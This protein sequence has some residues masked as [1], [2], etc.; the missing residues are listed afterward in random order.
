MRILGISNMRIPLT[1][2]LV[3]HVTTA[4]SLETSAFPYPKSTFPAGDLGPL[5]VVS[6]QNVTERADIVTLQTLAG[7]LARTS[8]S[9]YVVSSDPSVSGSENADSTIFWLKEMQRQHP[10][11][12]ISFRHLRGDLIGLLQRFR[13][14]ITGY[15]RFDPTTN[16]TNAAINYCAGAQGNVIAAKDGDALNEM[17]IPM[18]ADVSDL[19]PYDVFLKFKANMSNRMAAFQ[20]DDG[21]KAQC[22]SAYAVFGRFPVV[23]HPTGGSIAFDDV[24]SNFREDALNAA[25]GWTSSDEHEYTA[26]ITEAGGMVHA[27][28]FLFNVEVL[29]NLPD[30]PNVDVSDDPIE[31][32][33]DD[34]EDVHTV[35]F[36][37][38]DGDNLQ[39]LA[40]GWISPSFYGSPLRG[41][42]PLGWS[43]SPAAAVLMPTALRYVRESMT[44][45]DSLSSGPS[46]A[47]YVYPQLFG[48][49]QQ[50]ALFADAT[51]TM[52][53]MSNMTVANVIGVVPSVESVDDLARQDNIEGLIYFTFGKASEGYSGLHGNFDY[54]HETPVVG[55]RLNMW[56]EAESGDKV[57]VDGLVHELSQLPK[58]RSDA[59]AYS[60]VVVHMGSHNYS[61]VVRATEALHE[62]GGFDVVLPETLLKRIAKNA[63][64]TCPMPFGEWSNVVGDLPKCS[65]ARNG[66]CMFS[67]SSVRRHVLPVSCDLKVC[68]NLT[69]S[70][71]SY[72]FVCPDGEKCP[73][74]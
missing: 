14:N 6:T 61:D 31:D 59:R 62:R 73:G 15:V 23:E 35:A 66:D 71:G 32:A 60:I 25:M 42:A 54:V 58:D 12:D 65:I 43:Y 72:R 5:F 7:V 9:I 40:N 64:P 70:D 30:L 74:V 45:N 16:S 27:S 38:S 11:L 67:C 18:V 28:D 1:L 2:L 26:R 56:D 55:L 8:P 50:R 10:T 3:T 69:L 17:G 37:M 53:R 63:I 39:L 29:S 46:G 49:A 68:N 51:A 36:V 4:S 33:H 34:V 20:P 22:L 19:G 57:G 52:M 47:G 41:R 13:S 21:S 44:R 24:L 48:S